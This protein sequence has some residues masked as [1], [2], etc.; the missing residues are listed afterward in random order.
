MHSINK[1]SAWLWLKAQQTP[2]NG[3][4]VHRLQVRTPICHI[5]PVSRAYPYTPP[6]PK[7]T[8]SIFCIFLRRSGFTK[9]L[10]LWTLFLYFPRKASLWALF[11]YSLGKTDERAEFRNFWGWGVGV[12]NRRDIHKLRSVKDRI[13]DPLIS[14]LRFFARS[15]RFRHSQSFSN[16]TPS[17]EAVALTGC[18]DSG[19]T[20][21]TLSGQGDCS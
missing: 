14:K 10:G 11:L 8:K 17:T 9:T 21:K 13:C 18:E 16:K 7:V 15:E 12:R 20:S 4:N 3:Q 5:V 2:Q 6:T 1:A 19:L